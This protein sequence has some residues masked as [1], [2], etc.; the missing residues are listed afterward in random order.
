MAFCK[1]KKVV[2]YIA[3]Q[4]IC[5]CK[6]VCMNN[7]M[8]WKTYVCI[9]TRPR[10]RWDS[11]SCTE[12]KR[13]VLFILL[14]MN[15]TV[16][17]DIARILRRYPCRQLRLQAQQLWAYHPW[18]DAQRPFHSEFVRSQGA[19]MLCNEN[20]PAVLWPLTKVHIMASIRILIFD[21]PSSSSAS[22]FE[23][24]NSSY[25]VYSFKEIEYWNIISN[26]P[27]VHAHWRCGILRLDEAGWVKIYF[28]G[29]ACGNIHFDKWNDLNLQF[30]HVRPLVSVR[31]L[32][33]INGE[34]ENCCNVDVQFTLPKNSIWLLGSF[35]LLWLCAILHISYAIM[36]YQ[37][38]PLSM[39][40]WRDD[41]HTKH[42]RNLIPIKI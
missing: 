34:M 30:Y 15:E 23:H 1:Q 11:H 3:S 9:C 5:A 7:F 39:C 36:P 28:C 18:N 37:V 12:T 41:E 10:S 31:S 33:S 2:W 29:A 4:R 35:Q 20:W 38:C 40:V 17:C 6:C 16:R 27:G 26:R 22:L 42:D 32:Q 14:E 19:G 24:L 25:I 8:P 13:F 21:W